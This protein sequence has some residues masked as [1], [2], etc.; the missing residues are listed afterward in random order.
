MR[1]CCVL[2]L[3]R[4]AHYSWLDRARPV[5]GERAEADANARLLAAFAP[6]RELSSERESCFV[7]GL[8][9]PVCARLLRVVAGLA[10]ARALRRLVSVTEREAFAR[11]VGAGLLGELQRREGASPDCAFGVEPDFFSRADMTAAGLAL[12]MHASPALAERIW[13][14]LRLPREISVAAARFDVRMDEAGGAGAWLGEAW[15]LMQEATC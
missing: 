6:V 3:S 2:T 13:L 9:R 5:R 1:R 15:Q 12:A 14:Q 11:C 10:C 4:W 8:S 7:D